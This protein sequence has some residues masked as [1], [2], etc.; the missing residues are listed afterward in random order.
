MIQ[1]DKIRHFMSKSRRFRW[2]LT[3]MLAMVK[4]GKLIL[5]YEERA[6]CQLLLKEQRLTLSVCSSFANMKRKR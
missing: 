2:D 6:E 4:A 5:V 1:Y 3:V